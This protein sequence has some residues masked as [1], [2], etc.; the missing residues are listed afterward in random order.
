MYI[1]KFKIIRSDRGLKNGDI[2]GPW[3]LTR[4]AYKIMSALYVGSPS[5]SP[6]SKSSIL[7]ISS[8]TYASPT[9]AKPSHN[10]SPLNPPSP[11]PRPPRLLWYHLPLLPYLSL[12]HKPFNHH[13]ALAYPTQL[14]PALLPRQGLPGECTYQCEIYG[15][16]CYYA[17]PGAQPSNGTPY[18]G[19]IDC[20]GY[21]G[22]NPGSGRGYKQP[23]GTNLPGSPSR[24]E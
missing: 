15:C 2:T 11:S 3:S 10:V 22:G 8:T 20:C 16:T 23:T 12:P 17:L 19:G 6:S 9:I 5:R 7:Y 24:S 18:T 13:H 1:L 4:V 21:S 14:T